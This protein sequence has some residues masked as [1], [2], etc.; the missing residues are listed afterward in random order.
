MHKIDCS[1][2]D[3]FFLSL[4]KLAWRME[5]SWMVLDVQEWRKEA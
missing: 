4:L 1:Y 3:G 5:T 2:T